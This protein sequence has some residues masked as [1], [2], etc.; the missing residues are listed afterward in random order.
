M[1]EDQHIEM[2]SSESWEYSRNY[3]SLLGEIPSSFG[4]TIRSLISDH[5]KNAGVLGPGTKFLSLRLARSKSLKASFYYALQTYK[6]EFLQGKD[7]ITV[8]DLLNAFKADE[9]AAL[10]GTIYLYKKAKKI[11]DKTELNFIL[12]HLLKEIDVSGHVGLGLP[13]VGFAN[14]ILT[15]GMRY[16]AAMTYLRH[17]LK[18]FQEYR[19]LLKSEK[20]LFNHDKEI[21]FFGCTTTQIA[22]IFLQTLGFGVEFSNNYAMTFADEKIL[23]KTDA[24]SSPFKVTELWTYSLIS[25]GKI[26]DV[27]HDSKFYPANKE[28]TSRLLER[29]A[30]APTSWLDRG[31][32]D[33]SPEKTPQ[34]SMEAEAKAVGKKSQSTEESMSGDLEDDELEQDE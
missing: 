13:A 7:K 27:A 30:A 15:F 26:P 31:S 25:G 3:S 22:S 28:I 33:I 18:H 8:E 9:I 1:S 4:S 20:T 5:E 23:Q 11:C 10:L 16:I 6:P 17:N 34:L 29:V 24:Q 32:E 14:G 21:E 19:R 2:Y 12:P